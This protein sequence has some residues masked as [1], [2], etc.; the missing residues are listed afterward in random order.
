MG[1][2]GIYLNTIKALYDNPTTTT[3]LN[4]EKLEAFTLRYRTRQGCPLSPF[5]FNIVLLVLA[6][7][8]R[9]EKGIKGISMRKEEVKLSLFLDDMILHRGNKRFQYGAIGTYKTVWQS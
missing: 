3:I 1:I 7:V 8:D 4:R 6:R 2:K 9:E 5:L